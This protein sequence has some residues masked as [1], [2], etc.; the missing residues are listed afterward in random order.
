MIKKTVLEDLDAKISLILEKYTLM[1]SE[2]LSLEE[3]NKRLKSDFNLLKE[4]FQAK[5]QEI[6]KLQEEEELKDLELE[7]IVHRIN[8][9][10]GLVN[11]KEESVA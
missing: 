1:K 4:A 5:N 11:E 10:I 7:D 6:E 2:K 9:V 3:E 8:K